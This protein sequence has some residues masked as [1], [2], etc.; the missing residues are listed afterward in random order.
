MNLIYK[1]SKKPVKVGD[2]VVVGGVTT[3][4]DHFP[5]PHKPNS[6]GKVTLGTGATY[7]VSVIGAEWVD[8][9]DRAG[10]ASAVA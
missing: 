4:V 1:D 6:E 7:Y 10:W 8:R 3:T 5:Q 2:P 9:E